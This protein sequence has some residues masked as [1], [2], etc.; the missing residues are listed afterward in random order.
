MASWTNLSKRNLSY[1]LS[2]YSLFTYSCDIL[3]IMEDIEENSGTIS[4][5]ESSKTS[6][7]KKFPKPSI[8]NNLKLAG[9]ALA[10]VL[11]GVSSGWFLNKSS[12]SSVGENE[13]VPGVTTTESEA[14]LEDGSVF[15]DTAEGQLEEGGIEGEGTHHL[16]REGGPSKYVYLTSTIIDLQ[17]FV[18]KK[19]TV[20]G[21]TLSGKQAGWLMD[22]GK[23]KVSE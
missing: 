18:G 12:V 23:V 9:L 13:K 20:W 6:L 16:V 17:S 7:L 19:V 5:V 8:K 3:N 21:E 2:R 1:L 4:A 10:V 11:L 22:V 15:P 14:G